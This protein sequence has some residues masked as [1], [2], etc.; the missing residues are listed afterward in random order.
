MGEK[1]VLLQSTCESLNHINIRLWSRIHC[2]KENSLTGIHSR[3]FILTNITMRVKELL[4]KS[5]FTIISKYFHYLF[6]K[7]LSSF[8]F[9]NFENTKATNHRRKEVTSNI[10]NAYLDKTIKCL[11]DDSFIDVNLNFVSIY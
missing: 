10:N 3:R 2:L 8:S 6:L 9:R 4:I 5:E 1:N 11:C 7:T